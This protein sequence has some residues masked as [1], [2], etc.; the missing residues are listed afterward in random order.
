MFIIKTQASRNMK[1]FSEAARR[2]EEASV[3]CKGEDRV[4]L[5]RRWLVSLREFEKLD[6]SLVE[7]DGKSSEDPS[8]PSDKNVTPGKSTMV[9]EKTGFVFV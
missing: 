8:S 2:L 4:Q 5:L 6:G 1:S 9:S 7:I 3:S